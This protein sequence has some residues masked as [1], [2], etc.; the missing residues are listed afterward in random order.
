MACWNQGLVRGSRSDA[1][2][3]RCFATACASQSV[4][5]RTPAAAGSRARLSQPSPSRRRKYSAPSVSASLAPAIWGMWARIGIRRW[6]SGCSSPGPMSA[7]SSPSLR[8]SNCCAAGRTRASTSS[9][10]WAVAARMRSWAR[11]SRRASNRNALSAASSPPVST[12]SRIR[13]RAS[14]A[15]R[16][17]LPRKMVVGFRGSAPRLGCGHSIRAGAPGA[18]RGK[19][20]GTRPTL[21]AMTMRVS[22]SP[23]RMKSTKR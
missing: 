20:Q 23:T 16:G 13:S 6:L 21:R 4:R 22:G 9:R 8:M 7:T 18:Q 2:A 10:T 5:C 17:R 14:R 3:S 19:S 11:S 1:R 15:R 12:R